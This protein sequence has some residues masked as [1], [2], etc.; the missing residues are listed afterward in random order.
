VLLSSDVLL[1]VFRN[2]ILTDACPV[3]FLIIKKSEPTVVYV[4]L[5]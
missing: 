4:P 5:L 2:S 3:F 1:R